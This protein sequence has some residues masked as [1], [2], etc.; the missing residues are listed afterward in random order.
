MRPKVTYIL[1][2]K[3]NSLT[4]LRTKP[5]VEPNRMTRMRTN[6]IASEMLVQFMQSDFFSLSPSHLPTL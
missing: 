4:L 3:T 2:L 6:E 5:V 1:S